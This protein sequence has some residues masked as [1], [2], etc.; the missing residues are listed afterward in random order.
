MSDSV[1]ADPTVNSSGGGLPL[2]HL[3]VVVG[4][5]LQFS[6]ATLLIELFS[7]VGDQADCGPRRASLCEEGSALLGLGAPV[8][9]AGILVF[10]LLDRRVGWSGPAMVFSG[11]SLMYGAAGTG[12]AFAWNAATA[13]SA[14]WAVLSGLIALLPLWVTV[15]LI[16]GFLTG[17]RGDGIRKWAETTFWILE[18]LPRSKRRRKQLARSRGIASSRTR[19]GRLVPETRR[20]RMHWSLFT[21]E[22]CVA[23]ACGVLAAWLFVGAVS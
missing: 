13:D 17:M 21:A 9:I 18:D 22:S 7:R 12:L 14:G 2:R 19:T 15:V 16:R 6:G 5:F 20:E 8:F 23:L 10:G 11:L 3:Y 1:G 4:I